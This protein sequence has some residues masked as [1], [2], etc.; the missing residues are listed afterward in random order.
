MYLHE[1]VSHITLK[2]TSKFYPHKPLAAP[3]W[4]EVKMEELHSKQNRR[5]STGKTA[6]VKMRTPRKAANRTA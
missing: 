1:K 2:S 5:T 4:K 3:A 6:R